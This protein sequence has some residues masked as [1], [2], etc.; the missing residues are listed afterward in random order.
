L[1]L[2]TGCTAPI[3]TAVDRSNGCGEARGRW[4]ALHSPAKV[5]A[6]VGLEKNGQFQRPQEF[7]APLM[8]IKSLR[9]MCSYS[10]Q[11]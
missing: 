4:R 7:L 8:C 1:A 11:Q 6:F 10:P 2:G 3:S 5:A 9:A